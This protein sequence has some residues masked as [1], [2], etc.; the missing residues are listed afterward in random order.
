MY[1]LEKRLSTYHEKKWICKGYT[2]SCT[3]FLH[4]RI[5]IWPPRFLLERITRNSWSLTGF[6]LVVEKHSKNRGFKWAV[7]KRLVAFYTGW[8]I[9]YLCDVAIKKK[10]SA[11]VQVVESLCRIQQYSDDR[12]HSLTNRAWKL[13]V[14]R[15]SGFLFGALP[16]GD[17]E[18]DKMP[19]SWDWRSLDGRNSPPVTSFGIWVARNVTKWNTWD[20][21]QFFFYAK[22][23]TQQSHDGAWHGQ[24]RP[25]SA[26][27]P[28]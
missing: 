16:Q 3:N 1:H 14:G 12:L 25:T 4:P 23:Q 11:E 27:A 6:L 20:L 18:D 2:F 24:N 19:E 21:G 15:R 17:D 28:T 7:F 13:M 26:A 9:W 8:F 5:S 10:H 22:T